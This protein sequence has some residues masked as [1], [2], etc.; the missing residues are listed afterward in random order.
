MK[1]YLLIVAG[2]ALLGLSALK[3]VWLTHLLFAGTDRPPMFF[4]KQAVYAAAF[5]GMGVGVARTGWRQ[6]GSA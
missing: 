4:V 6:R 2:L 5:F 1:A 3:A